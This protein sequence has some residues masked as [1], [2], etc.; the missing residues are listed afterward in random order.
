MWELH[1]KES[2][3]LKDWCFWTVVLKKTPE[4]PLDCKEIK[5]V[6]PKGNQSWIFIGR[7]DAEAEAPILWPPDA[8]NWLIEKTLMLGKIEGM[9]RWQQR[10]RWLD[11]ITDSVDMILSKL[12]ELVMDR[13][14]WPVHV[15]QSLES[16]R[17]GHDWTELNWTKGTY[18][19]TWVWSEVCSLFSFFSFPFPLPLFL[20]SQIRSCSEVS[21]DMNFWG[22]LFNP[23]QSVFFI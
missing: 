19:P 14:A 5:P 23:V 21:V 15:L 6:N 16:Q 4:S 17:I 22:A 11:G 20:S 9:R 12:Q 8:K 7:T 18:S 10:M 2:W 1:H 13:E 3:V